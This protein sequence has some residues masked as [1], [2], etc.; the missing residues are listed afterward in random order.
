M[1]LLGFKVIVVYFRLIPYLQ[2][3]RIPHMTED[4]Y[5]TEGLHKFGLSTT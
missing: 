5:S 3:L 4:S 1:I 2:R